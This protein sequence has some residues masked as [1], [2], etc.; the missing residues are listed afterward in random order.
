MVRLA[1]I[2]VVIM[3]KIGHVKR[4]Q[5]SILRTRQNCQFWRLLG[6][7]KMPKMEFSG[8]CGLNEVSHGQIGSNLVKPSTNYRT[9]ARECQRMFVC[10]LLPYG[11]PLLLMTQYAILYLVKL[12]KIVTST[13]FDARHVI[14]K[15]RL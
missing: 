8:D 2:N 13:D 3:H 15:L 6:L 1:R 4:S 12:W 11:Q 9:R 10:T 14:L 7:S 5:T